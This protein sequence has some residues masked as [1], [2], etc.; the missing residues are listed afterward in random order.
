LLPICPLSGAFLDVG[1]DELSDVLLQ[2][3][4]GE[5]LHHEGSQL[6]VEIGEENHVSFAHLV[7]HAHQ[8]TLAEGSSLGGFH[9]RDVGDVAVI[10]NGVVI[11]EVAHVLDETVVSDGYVSQGGIV[12]A[13]MLYEALAHLHILVDWQNVPKELYLQAMERSPINDLE[14]RTLLSENLTPKID[15]REVIFKGIEQSYYYE[16]YEILNKLEV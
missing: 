13:G 15:D 3:L 16:G 10:T 1:L 7:E 9:R 8:I 6:T 12:D 4:V 5:M 2:F 14:I 11:D